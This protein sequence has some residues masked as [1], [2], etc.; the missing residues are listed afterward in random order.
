MKTKKIISVATLTLLILLGYGFNT[1]TE[2]EV[3]REIRFANVPVSLQLEELPEPSDPVKIKLE[4]Q[5]IEIKEINAPLIGK[6]YIGFKEALGF[7]ESR[8]NYSIV[9]TLGYMGKYQFGT[10]TLALLGIRD[11][12]Q[13]LHSAELQEIVFAA[14]LSRNKWV[15]RRE[16]KN[17]SGLKINGILITESGLLAAAHLAGP[18]NVKKYLRSKGAA[19]VKDAY[20]TSIEDYL[21]LFSG[22]DLSI[23]QARKGIKIK[24]GHNDRVS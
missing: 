12:I 13:F 11:S 6:N 16:I 22:F 17:Y 20:G 7:K 9:N 1:Y 21:N 10:G 14:N 2:T 4:E 23:I 18:G 3:V 19:I 15:L 8:G 5:K 24:W